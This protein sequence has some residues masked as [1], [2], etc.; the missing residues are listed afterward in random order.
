[1]SNNLPPIYFY[2]PQSYLPATIPANADE[3]WQGFGL[4][5][6]A[7]TL[8][9]YLRLKTDGFPCELVKKIPQEGIVLV[10]RNAL[11]SHK[12]KL[13]PG[14]KL[15]LICL[16]ADLNS[17][18][19]TQLHVVQNPLETQIIPQSYFIPHWTQ[20]GL[21]KRDPARGDRFETIAFFGHQDNLAS[22]FLK[23]SWQNA[24][25]TLGLHWQP[26]INRNP[27]HDY[28]KI[29]N[30]WHDYS[31]IDGIVAVRSFERRNHNL[32]ANYLNKPATKLYN[33]WLAGIPAIL[34][35]ESAYQAERQSELDYLEVISFNET[36]SALKRLRDNPVLRQAMIENGHIRAEAIQPSIITQRW[37]KFLI[38]IAIPAYDDWCKQPPLV[39]QIILG[40]NYLGFALKRIQDKL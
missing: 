21:I 9:T 26:I 38:D 20:P 28:S 33:A 13:K 24:L 1:M 4:G 23:P 11:R 2:I 39:Q 19:Y 6:H 12:N 37:R 29:N 16:K 40:Y 8:Q 15:L 25:N 34:G 10:H 18:P 27:W 31:Q 3:N 36:I 22:E 35:C 14:K 30:N 32:N 7:W 5:I 17:Y